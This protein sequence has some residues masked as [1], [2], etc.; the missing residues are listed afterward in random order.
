[1]AFDTLQLM[2]AQ[3]Q[4]PG[5]VVYNSLIEACVNNDEMDK[6]WSVIDHMCESNIEPDRYSY[7][8]LFKGIK[9]HRYKTQ[10]NRALELVYSW[11]VEDSLKLK[12][13]YNVL[14]NACIN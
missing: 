14:L 13:C 7:C 2:K 11:S 5:C 3:N 1:M 9:D 6:A 4:L 10:L 8:F 12:Y